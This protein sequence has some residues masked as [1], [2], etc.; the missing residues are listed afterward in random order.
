MVR[1]RIWLKIHSG[2]IT[3]KRIEEELL[4]FHVTVHFDLVYVLPNIIKC[5]LAVLELY[6]AHDFSLAEIKYIT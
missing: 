3:R 1:T 5:S 4:F 2:E 6:P